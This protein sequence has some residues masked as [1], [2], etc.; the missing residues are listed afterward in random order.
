MPEGWHSPP[1][2]CGKYT[3]K[4]IGFN[5]VIVGS[6]GNAT[7]IYKDIEKQERSAGNIFVGFLSVYDKDDY[8]IG[9]Y[10]PHLGPYQNLKKSW[11][12]TMWKR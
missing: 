1:S 10:L 4:E 8:K 2:L 6:N 7:K 3:A 5:T 12:N 9:Q 11:K